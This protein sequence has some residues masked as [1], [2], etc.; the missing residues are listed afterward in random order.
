[1]NANASSPAGANKPA[2]PLPEAPFF[3]VLKQW[4]SPALCV[5]LCVFVLLEVNYPRMGPQG[6]LAI[7]AMIGLAL[8]FLN[9]PLHA[10]CQG[11]SAARIADCVFLLLTAVSCG[12]VVVQ[13]EPTFQAFWLE[14]KS[15][16][17][18]AG[19]VV[20]TDYWM[21]LIGLIV[22]IEGTRRSIG[23]AL[24]ILSMIFILYAYF[25][26]QLPDFLFPH[27]G[28]KPYD[29]VAATFLKDLGIFGI[30]LNVMFKY[31]FL[32]VIF[33]SFLEVTGGTQFI[34][35]FSRRVF[36]GSPG[37]PAKVA[38]LGSGLMGSLSGSAVANAVTTG[39]FTIPMMRS[40]GFPRHIAGGITAAAASGGA[41][42]PPIMGAGAYMMLEI[43]EPKVAF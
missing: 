14:G 35:D 36:G 43:I 18:R 39:A 11:Y 19:L 33:G 2:Q 25:G 4:L 9:F 13:T 38:V 29:I 15:L 27:A 10:K 37:G 16:G 23:W 41:L 28:M 5:L 42:V 20:A 8:C 1:M 7:F 21:G 12:Y 26:P 31:V 3:A 30:A 32:F 17:D 24:P 40:A 6:E 22:V 34:I